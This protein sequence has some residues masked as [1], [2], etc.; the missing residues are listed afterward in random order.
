[1]MPSLRKSPCLLALLTLLVAGAPLRAATDL[2]LESPGFDLGLDAEGIFD[3]ASSV[4]F[5]LDVA[6]ATDRSMEAAAFLGAQAVDL[7]SAATSSP[8]ISAQGEMNQ[9]PAKKGG[10]G[11]WLKKHWWVPVV[12]GVAVGVA[13]SG[14][15]SDDGDVED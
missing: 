14:D 1:M 12:V 5:P 3:S 6:P 4:A 11:H 2:G 10:A 13:V 7:R 15:S 8:E 9:A